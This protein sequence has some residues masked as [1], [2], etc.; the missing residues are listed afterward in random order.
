M[1]TKHTW[2]PAI[3]GV[4]L[5]LLA[6]LGAWPQPAS[7]QLSGDTFTITAQI[8]TN[9]G[10]GPFATDITV[11]P[12]A[13]LADGSGTLG[14]YPRAGESVD[15]DNSKCVFRF[16]ALGLQGAFELSGL[17]SLIERDLLEITITG[18]MVASSDSN[19]TVANPGGGSF[20]RFTVDCNPFLT[21][22]PC[23][24]GTVEVNFTFAPAGGGVAG[25]PLQALND[26]RDAVIAQGFIPDAET[27]LLNKLDNAIAK[28]EDGNPN[29]DGAAASNLSGFIDVVMMKQ[30][31]GS[32]GAIGDALIAVAEEII[33]LIQAA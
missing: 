23:Q 5:G 9:Q 27:P 20:A 16:A 33:G 26:L 1:M 13:E 22:N 18:N 28:L 21:V 7:A 2:F 17:D 14:G 3:W 10:T 4:A 19:L 6:A 24:G 11:G 8:H 31:M 12:G 25:D 30:E 15:C 29:N 32:I